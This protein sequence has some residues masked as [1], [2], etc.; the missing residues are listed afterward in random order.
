MDIMSIYKYGSM[1]HAHENEKLNVP[2]IQWLGLRTSDV[3]AEADHQGD[4]PLIPLTTRDRKKAVSMLK[5]NPAFAEDGPETEWRLE[6]QQMLM[7]NLKVETEILYE[8][9]GGLEG[10]IHRHMKEQ[11]SS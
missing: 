10:W 2:G 11:A 6:L 4:D 7:L 5:N 8:R 3:V 9:E 1:A